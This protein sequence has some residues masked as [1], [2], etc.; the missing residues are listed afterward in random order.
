MSL[1]NAFVREGHLP[2]IIIMLNAHVIDCCSLVLKFH[3]NRAELI[4]M[5]IK[6]LYLKGFSVS[7]YLHSPAALFACA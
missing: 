3:I 1:V 5:M 6:A 4:I 2:V 7:K